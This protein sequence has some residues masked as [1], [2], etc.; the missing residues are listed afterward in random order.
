MSNV[1]EEVK[2]V[3]K[4]L[5]E[6][7]ETA[8][9]V[10][11]Q[12]KQWIVSHKALERVA[13]R[14]NIKFDAPVI[15]ES[16]INDKS[17]AIVVTGH[18]GDQTQWSFGEAADYN[19]KMGY[20]FAMAEKRAKDRVILKLVGLHGYVY[21]EDEAEEF[22]E[23]KPKDFKDVPGDL[24]SPEQAR[25]IVNLMVETQTLE[26]KFCQAFEITKLDRLPAS[27]FKTAKEMLEKK[28]ENKLNKQGA[29]DA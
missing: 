24:I 21:S 8:G 2:K 26:S 22:Q 5:G 23:S 16:H 28:L 3:L 15:V 12:S 29:A 19:N 7:A 13:A 6:T 11:R 20:P 18:L 4:E 27:K 10:H 17:V 14:K 1:P 25:E 9:W